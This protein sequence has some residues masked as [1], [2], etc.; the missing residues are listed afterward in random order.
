LK[1]I[2]IWATVKESLGFYF[3][4]FN[5]LFLISLAGAA[6]AALTA[7]A[8]V[9][10]SVLLTVL[11]FPFSIAGIIVGLWAGIA[12]ITSA[13]ALYNRK[14]TGFM[15]AFKSAWPKMWPYI[16]N[17][18]FLS[19]I[20][21]LGFVVLA[22]PGFYLAVIFSF[23]TVAVVVE[24]HKKISPFKFS[25]ALVKNNFWTVFLYGLAVALTLLPVGIVCLIAMIPFWDSLKQGATNP[26]LSLIMQIVSAAIMPFP[27]AANYVLY[28]K[29][30]KL[31][32]RT[33][34]LRDKKSLAPGR[35]GCLIFCGLL[36]AC[37]ILAVIVFLLVKNHLPAMPGAYR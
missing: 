30:K 34:D 16:Y 28:A 37:I 17:S 10:G 36:L 23:V 3:K 11:V 2:G 35:W 14:K 24:D 22:I 26:A 20:V 32:Q 9:K 31:K 8:P 5:L 29:L 4:N 21:L 7:I 25:A 19:M 27:L 18:L 15:A 13:A 1:K 12:I 6:L 33:P